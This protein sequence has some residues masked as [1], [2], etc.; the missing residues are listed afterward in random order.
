[1]D[2]KTG[3]SMGFGFLHMGTA[4]DLDAAVEKGS[5]LV[6]DGKELK[7]THAK[8][9]GGVKP[10]QVQGG[11]LSPVTSFPKPDLPPTKSSHG[12]GEIKDNDC[13]VKLAAERVVADDVT[14]AGKGTSSSP[15]C[16]EQEENVENNMKGSLAS[17]EDEEEVSE[18]T[19]SQL[20]GL[21]TT[22]PMNIPN[23]TDMCI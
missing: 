13:E 23:H 11:G 21:F 18:R 10:N 2:N 19:T 9:A 8:R 20:S 12:G 3:V 16:P 7:V 14:I 6:I 22:T 5:K 4:A 17:D 15:D 1:M